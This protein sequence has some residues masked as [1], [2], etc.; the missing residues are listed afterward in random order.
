MHAR[1]NRILAS[2]GLTLMLA[3]SAAQAANYTVNWLS[4]APTPVGTAPPFV[5]NYNLPGIGNV[6]VSYTPN[7]DFI[8][9][10]A[11]VPPL[12]T[13]AVTFGPDTYAWTNE[14]T[15]GRTNLGLSGVINSSWTVTYTFPGTVPAGSIVLGVQGLGRRD[16][17]PGQSPAATISQAT[18][19][20]NGTLLGD[21]TA[22]QN[23]GPTLFTPGI[24]VFS[25]MNSLTG[26]GGADP[27]WNTGLAL[28]RIDDAV[29]TL[30]V[31]IDQT[32]GD[33]L[34]VNIGAI[35]PEPTSAALLSLA[36]AFALRRRSR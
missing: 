17:D 27:W 13:G 7:T 26:P 19:F 22:A 4:Y 10:R 2:V 35:V 21:Y 18:V 32:M 25:M 16:H 11:Q 30:T 29:N 28:V 15:L 31:H 3:V 8:E 1:T 12:N 34:G 24:G 6:Q 5:G 14:E 9:A 33:G 23:W 20:Q 36:A